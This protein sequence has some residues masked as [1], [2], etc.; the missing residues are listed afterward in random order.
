MA[1]QAAAPAPAASPKPDEASA[2]AVEVKATTADATTDGAAA[3]P[4]DDTKPETTSDSHPA[5]EE[6]A[7]T[8]VGEPATS[9][10]DGDNAEEK[11]TG[12]EAG[13]DANGVPKSNG[14]R[15]STSG[16]K[17]GKKQLKS[18]KSMANLNLDVTPGTYWWARMKGYAAWPVIICDEAM[19]P[20]SLLTKRPVSAI[21]PDGTY[22][23]DFA[24]N[25]K[26]VRDRRYPVMFLGTN[27]FAW[28]V[29]TELTRLDLEDVKRAVDNNDQGKKAKNLWEAWKV[30]SEG[31]TLEY[32]K[33]LLMD[34]EKAMAEDA[35]ERAAKEAEKAEKAAK[36]ARRKSKG[37]DDD[38][39]M[40]DAAGSSDSA[41]KKSAKKRKNDA[42]GNDEKPAKTPKT[43]LK[44]NGPKTP[45]ESS[46]T[47]TKKT[48]ASKAKNSKKV[49]ES[50]TPKVVEEEL[51]PEQKFE[52][53]SKAILYLR[54]RLQKGFLTR[55]Q[56]PKEEEMQQ[57]AEYFTQLE[58]HQDLEEKIIKDT[59]INKVLK[60]IIKLD[61][62]PKEEVYNFKKRSA[63]L[64]NAWGKNASGDA[65]PN[66]V[67]AKEDTAEAKSDKATTE[68][69]KTEGPK[70]EEPKSEEPKAEPRAEEASK[71]VEMKDAEDTPA[72]TK[73]EETKADEPKVED[74]KAAEP[75]DVAM[76][77]AKD[78]EKPAAATTEV[79]K[80]G[81]KVEE[82]S[83]EATA[84]S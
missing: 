16:E 84:A 78:P 3:A 69:P 59:K 7:A 55:D 38:V 5:A 42:E 82:K 1:D 65:K 6:P 39:E 25:G 10:K 29:N 27:E 26:N 49:E 35:Q 52:K 21:R 51:T 40:E 62:I 76:E 9:E 41:S 63:D 17:G 45:A 72:E 70:T 22:R 64:L 19:L 44:V 37:G 8:S 67:E 68:E 56:T 79:A 66:G 30:A 47:K 14:R 34:H 32:F 18:K 80:E 36:K 2:P 23:E 13:N 74:A 12:T 33:Q 46:A 28:Q 15:K 54:H 77:D 4:I 71:D 60:A 57:M 61:S 50:A 53:R 31:H 83:A 20:E 58:S 24:D 11:D 75:I 48:P 43:K 73:A 81:D